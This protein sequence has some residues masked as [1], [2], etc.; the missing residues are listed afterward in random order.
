MR[1]G[2]CFVWCLG[3]P[4]WSGI[5]LAETAAKPGTPTFTAAEVVIVTR[6]D[7]LTRTIGT[8][9]WLV[10][11]LLDKLADA[12]QPRGRDL[13][14]QRAPAGFDAGKN[15]DLVGSA[16]GSADGTYDLVQLIKKAAPQKEKK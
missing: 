5:A 12:A 4:L 1:T 8:D 9:P 10:R 7:L 14:G 2:L 15:P 3:L 13:V 6:N 16:R 11:R